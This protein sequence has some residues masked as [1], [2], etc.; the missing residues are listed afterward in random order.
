MILETLP[1]KY[2]VIDRLDPRV[3]ALCAIIA[4]LLP[5]FLTSLDAL[6]VALGI[7]LFLVI[8]ERVQPKGVLRRVLAVNVFVLT[9]IALLPWSVP[10]ETLLSLGRFSYS[11]EGLLQATTIALRANTILL[12]MI[13][14]V[15][16]L[17]PVTFA[18]ALE[19]LKMPSR[20]VQLYLFTIRYVA[21]IEEEYAQLRTAMSIR[22]FQPRLN[23]HTLRS[24]GYLIGMLLVRA[25]DRSE[26]ITNAM[27]CRGFTGRFHTH[28]HF[29]MGRV[30]SL[31][32]IALAGVVAGLLW[33]EMS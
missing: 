7:A 33:L 16:T 14:F 19:R 31:F 32:P 5:L 15:S 4:A 27:K 12:L 2:S 17:E 20:M 21:V 26:R 1:H 3:R 11:R 9:L 13:S 22:G 29:R 28:Q 6:L 25:L 18:H 24:F 10:G 30:D 8:Y 23:R